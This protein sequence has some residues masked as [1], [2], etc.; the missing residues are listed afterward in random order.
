MIEL[1][2]SH[3]ASEIVPYNLA[4]LMIHAK[5]YW[6][7]YYPN[8]SMVSHWHNDFE[9]IIC[10]EG[11]MLYF[12]NGTE[13]LLNKGQGIFVNAGMLH[14]GRT[15]KS[16]DDCQFLCMLFHPSLFNINSF[17]QDNFALS[18][19]QNQTFPFLLLSP[20]VD[21]QQSILTK[22]HIIYE[23][24]TLQN[25]GF[26]L[27]VLSHFYALWHTLYLNLSYTNNRQPLVIDKRLSALQLMIGFLQKDYS[28]HITLNQIALAGSVC[29]SSCCD[30]FANSYI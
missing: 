9:F 10:L 6:L 15:I 19:S 18:I 14:Y 3:D 24:I 23:V 22:L 5:T 27:V 30:I 21:W 29:R 2:L 12:V 16:Q 11:Q 13:L 1:Q 17:L 25:N 28:K 7:S 4:N 8:M 20:N 26:E